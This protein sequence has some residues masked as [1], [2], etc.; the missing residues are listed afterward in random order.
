MKHSHRSGAG[1][2]PGAFAATAPRPIPA[3]RS[4]DDPRLYF[5]REL[6]WLDYAW[7]LL[8]RARDSRVPVPMRLHALASTADFLDEFFS[9]RVGGLKRQ[10]LSNVVEAGPDRYSTREQLSLIR[11]AAV[12]LYSAMAETWKLDLRE[13]LGNVGFRGLSTYSELSPAQEQQL[14]RTFVKNVLPTLTPLAVDPGHPF[15]FISNLSLSLA[16]TLKHPIRGTHH[17]ARVKIPHIL[18]RWMEVDGSIVAVVEVVRH[19]LQDLF[20]GMVITGA[21]A[22]RVTRNADVRDNE[23]EADD[24]LSMISERLRRR[25]FA[26]VVRMEVESSMP[27]PVR[28]LFDSSPHHRRNRCV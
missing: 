5:N 2:A 20:R 10:L 15:P 16:V 1:E 17:F 23:E 26:P 9:K 24:L 14:R 19:N 22:F 4:L 8:A 12:P 18:Q 25:R 27:P 3:G 7:R 28:D 6:S 13:A 11:K 21:Y